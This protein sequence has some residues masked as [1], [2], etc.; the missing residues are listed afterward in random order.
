MLIRE[1]IENNCE[2]IQLTRPVK[3]EVIQI[4]STLLSINANTM[5]VE[6]FLPLVISF[7]VSH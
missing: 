4:Y 7:L 2:T 1:I 3:N 6:P 5:N